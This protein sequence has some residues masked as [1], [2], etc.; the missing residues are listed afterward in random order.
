[1]SLPRPESPSQI[2]IHPFASVVLRENFLK[3]PFVRRVGI[4]LPPGYNESRR[5][6]VVYLL[7][8]FTGRG[9]MMLNESAWEENIQERLDRLIT[10][11]IIQ[12]LIA[13]LPDCFTR[14]GGSQY[15]NSA[16][17]GRY[18]DHVIAELV[19]W[20]DAAFRTVPDRSH[21]A[22]AGKS[23]GGFGAV[24]LGMRHPEVFG[25]VACHSGDMHFDLCYRPDFAPTLRS[26]ARYGGV[27]KFIE[28]FQ[29]IH[30][31][32]GDFHSILSTVGYASCYSPKVEAPWGF[33][34]PFDVE[35]GEWRDEVWARWRA[36]DPIELVSPY[37]DALRSLQLLFLDC[38]TRDEFNLQFGARTFVARLGRSGIPYRHEEFD[39]G[40]FDI[41]YRYDVSLKAISDAWGA[42]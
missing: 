36:W 10:A 11:G 16:G 9:T 19:P 39:D 20:V 17:T 24:T 4:Y 22:V 25:A 27:Q 42:S 38:G 34:L 33:E 13:V 6:P 28:T 18:E 3:D 41:Q 2:I 29:T 15:I 14:Y 30:P 12:P 23:S 8:G 26:L 37:A 35:S 40:H 5:Y 1:M 32:K 31:K 7:A 21:R